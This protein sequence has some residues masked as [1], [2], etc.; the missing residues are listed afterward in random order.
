M[1]LDNYNDRLRQLSM[2]ELQFNYSSWLTGRHLLTTLVVLVP[3]LKQLY[4]S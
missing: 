3:G 4:S 2:A 1:F